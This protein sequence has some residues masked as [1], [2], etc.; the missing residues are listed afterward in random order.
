MLRNER[1]SFC[2]VK[3]AGI[4]AGDQKP[5][6]INSAILTTIIFT[7]MVSSATVRAAG[8]LD[9]TFN[10]AA[11][12][13]AG[14]SANPPMIVQPDGK[15]IIGFFDWGVNNGIAA[16]GIT[17]F[18]PDGTVDASFNPPR[19]SSGTVASFGLQ[20]NGKILIRGSFTL[21]NS[22]YKGIA[23]LNT[24]GSLDTTFNMI[25]TPLPNEGYEIFVQPDDSF[26]T[27]SV[28][29]FD[30]NGFPV[31]S[32]QYQPYV[33]WASNIAGLPDGKVYVGFQ[34]PMSSG[35][36]YL[37]RHNTDGTRDNSFSGVQPNRNIRKMIV[38]PDGK[39]LI[40]GPFTFV[41]STPVGRIARLNTD[42]SV[43][44]TFNP[45]GAGANSDISDV[46]LLPDGK[47]LIGGSFDSYNGITKRRFARLNSDG[48][49]DSS[50]T[51]NGYLGLFND[52]SVGNLEVLPSGKIVASGHL[53]GLQQLR[54]SII[55]LNA[56]GSQSSEFFVQKALYPQRIRK[57]TVQADGKL[58][59]AGEFGRI[60]GYERKSV[61]RLNP[62]GTVDTSFVPFFQT[63]GGGQ[64]IHQVLV[65]PDGRILL[66]F[67]NGFVVARLNPN[68]TRDTS[69]TSPLPSSASVYDLAL[70]ADG[71]ILIAGESA[72]AGNPAIFMRLNSDGSVDTTYN[73][74][75][76][77]DVV[78]R[79]LVQP[80]GKSIICGEFTQISTSSRNRIARYNADGTLDQTFNPSG[81]ANGDIYDIDLQTDGKIVVGG[82]FSTLNGSSERNKIGR[83]NPDGSLD[84]SFAQTANTVVQT[85]KVQPDGKV[86]IGGLFADV[87]GVPREK[88]ARLNADGSLDSTFNASA[89]ALVFDINLQAD[90]K[91]LVAGD[92]TK[93][94]N[95]LKM[96]V[97]RL[98]NSAPPDNLFDYDGDGRAD[99]S[100]FRPSENK[101]Y[102]L[103]SSNSTVAENIFA[104]AGDVPAPA[105]FDGDGKTD[106]AVFRP[107]SGDWWYLSSINNAQVFAHWG[108]TD[109]VPRPSDFD[110]D[111]KADYIVYRPSNSVWYRLG[112][113]GAT[114]ILAFGI[115]EDKPLVGDFDGDGKSD[116]A[117][118]RPST[119]HWWYAASASGGQF[120]AVHWGQN[121]D[122]PAPADFDGDGKTDFAVYRPS[123]GVWYILQSSNQSFT[124][125]HFGIAEDKPVPADYDGDGRAD[126]AVF[127]PSSGVWYLLRST[128]G[129][130][131]LQ[132]GSAGDI[133]TE[134]AFIP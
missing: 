6:K 84:L 49:L 36:D 3:S 105:D 111:G 41:N 96:S 131:A 69:F 47:I 60:N 85:V 78:Y 79:V 35:F 16:K 52:A 108:Q 46:E 19:L 43:D 97:A 101:W 30:A 59:L 62:D 64:I 24:D 55:I 38:L 1:K 27:G 48:T 45:G 29:K 37:T 33:A 121:G 9:S 61:A 107:S 23:R 116:P 20:S 113:T 22:P 125:L 100:V 93:V 118:F 10:V 120:S 88:L 132:F 25:T 44:S 91:I 53:Y 63:Q 32:F 4:L 39:L 7:L 13:I 81:G 70:Q 128:S 114:S 31:N 122:I 126:I 109:D 95:V 56:D 90:G 103:R 14:Y 28:Y 67:S 115:A 83:L 12:Q 102:I 50:F 73:P 11:Y 82:T 110:G 5:M 77:N 89:D 86:L 34:V 71:K 65:Q 58:Y 57:T 134:N 21:E 123:N 66:A 51:F 8:E 75:M 15:V 104:I 80:D 72:A 98:N 92:F 54:A 112:T 119:G 127:R 2:A 106:I 130:T 74:P 124:I 94:N 40:A 42:G 76:P 117:I 99:V 18:N 68:G 129:F 17:R 133:P 26:F 87:G